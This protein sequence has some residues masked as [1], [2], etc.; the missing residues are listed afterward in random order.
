MTI[1]PE[2]TNEITNLDLLFNT[3]NTITTGR[4]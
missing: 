3:L 4:F 1:N 2:T